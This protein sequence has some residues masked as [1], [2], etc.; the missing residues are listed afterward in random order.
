MAPPR[1][2]ALYEEIA[3]NGKG[4]KARPSRATVSHLRYCPACFQQELQEYGEAYWHRAHQIKASQACAKHNCLLLDST[5]AIHHAEYTMR[6]A[7]KRTCP[8]QTVTESTAAQQLLSQYNEDVLAL[9]FSLG[10]SYSM[11]SVF[12]YLCASG[13]IDITPKQTKINATAISQLLEQTFGLDAVRLAFPS[14]ERMLVTIRQLF[15]SNAFA[16]PEPYI[17]TL[18][19]TGLSANTLLEI[20][21][22]ATPQN[23]PIADAKILL[24]KMSQSSSVYTKSLV[25]RKLA[26]SAAELDAMMQELGFEIL[27]L[28]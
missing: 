25:A 10:S 28:I 3:Q 17:L 1:K 12:R 4:V 26:V 2:I 22:E 9:P 7:D 5:I 11:Q 23:L 27:I 18:A 21:N 8:D 15:T 14:E 13:F 16:S 24:L 6:C 19:A 20:N